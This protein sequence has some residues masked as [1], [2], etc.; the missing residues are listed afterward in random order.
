MLVSLSTVIILI[1]ICFL[2]D[3]LLVYLFANGKNSDLY[4]A[5]SEICLFM[6][7]WILGLIFQAAY[8][9]PYNINPIYFDYFVY[10]AACLMPVSFYKFSKIFSNT[11]YKLNKKL[12]II[13]ILSLLVLWTNDY[14]HLFYKQY[15]TNLS[16]TIYGTYF[17]VY[18]IYSYLL[19]AIAFI[20]LIKYSIKN[21]GLFS[22]QAILFLLGS[23]APLLVNILAFLGIISANIYLTPIC[24]VITILFFAIAIFK[25]NF[26][27]VAPIALQRIVDRMSD[28][29]L[30]VNSENIITDYNQTFI[31]TFKVENKNIRNKSLF[32][33]L[34]KAD[35]TLFKKKLESSR[36][37][38]KLISFKKVFSYINKTFTVEISSIINN[39]NY[40]G[41][42]IL[43]KDITQHELDKKK[44][45]DNQ[46]MLVEK[47]RLASLGQMIGGIAHNLKTPIFSVSGGIVALDDLIDEFESSVDD[48]TVNN[49][50]MHDI[51][52]DMKEWTGKLQTHISYMSDVITAV[53][54]QAVALSESQ[55]SDFSVDELFKHV[56]ILMK[57]ELKQ[58]LI[59][60]KIENNVSPK[61]TLHGNINALV[62]VINNLISNAIDAYDGQNLGPIEL[63]GN[64]KDNNIIISVKD[65][66][67]GLPEKVKEKLFKE[68]ITTKGKDGTGLG[69]F[70]SYSNIKA[71]FSGNITYESENNKGTTFNIIIPS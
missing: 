65:H 69:L 12:L 22:K 48:P 23:L 40:L 37:S 52:K 57:H 35:S 14:H 20:N 50:D 32:S 17:Y 58:A 64:Y 59:D 25:F 70:M 21:A 66:G 30:V 55:V 8:S 43:F 15:S 31:D 42:L 5:F 41:T 2:L 34:N 46:D 39:G 28:S 29:Y 53:K 4:K 49:D 61:V 63:I 54:G 3:V 71:H 47:E 11:K 18:T 56:D 6:I 19:F 24:F 16:E 38:N 27:K 26:L 9:K 62:Q 13:P 68:M 36:N 45:E 67:P 51:A 7:F 10:I 1:V 44:I 33:L 60:F